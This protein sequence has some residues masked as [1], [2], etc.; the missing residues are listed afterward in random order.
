MYSRKWSSSGCRPTTRMSRYYSNKT[1]SELFVVSAVRLADH[2]RLTTVDIKHFSNRIVVGLLDR[3]HRLHVTVGI[4]GLPKCE[5]PVHHGV[6]KPE[7]GVES[8]VIQVSHMSV[9]AGETMNDI[10]D[11]LQ[12]ICVRH[13]GVNPRLVPEFGELALRQLCEADVRPTSLTLL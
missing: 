6:M 3:C 12:R 10:V 1:A 5:A 7:D 11:R 2:A 8:R 9:R 13:S 4:E